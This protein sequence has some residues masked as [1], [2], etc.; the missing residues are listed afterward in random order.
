[1]SVN[2]PTGTGLSGATV[3]LKQSGSVKYNSNTDTSGNVEF[4]VDSGAYDLNVEPNDTAYEVYD[5]SGLDLTS[6]LSKTVTLSA[7]S[8]TYTASFTVKKQDGSAVS[9]ADVTLTKED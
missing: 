9:G 8:A 5:E 2:T 7:K 3:N 6:D 1:M 4:D